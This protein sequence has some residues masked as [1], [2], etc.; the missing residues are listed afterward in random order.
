VQNSVFS[1]NLTKCRSSKGCQ[2]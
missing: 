1:T 2:L